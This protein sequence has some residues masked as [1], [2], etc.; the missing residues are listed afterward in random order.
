[1][2]R[3]EIEQWLRKYGI[4]NYTINKNLV[5]D[6]DGGVNI[7]GKNLKK[8]PFQFGTVTGFF[9]CYGNKLTSLQHSPTS[10]GG[11]FWCNGNNITSLQYCPTTVSGGF[12]CS[13]NDLTSLQ[14][15][16]TTVG[17]DF[18]CYNNKLTSLQYCPTT[19]GGDFGCSNN[20]FQVTKE[21]EASWINAINM[22]KSVYRH[23]KDQA[24]P[25]MTNVYK[26]MWEL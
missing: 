15:C 17:G 26:L 20:T 23:V 19:V 25:A 13:N 14:Y 24:T 22:H 1:M 16:P 12:Y 11:S 10:I 6:V 18:Y 5:V 2:N 9:Y 7:S 21:N 8:L 4:K 3:K